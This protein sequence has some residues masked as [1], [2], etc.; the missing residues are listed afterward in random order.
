MAK[1]YGWCYDKQGNLKK[2]HA[3]VNAKG[4]E[5]KKHKKTVTGKIPDSVGFSGFRA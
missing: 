4:K 1:N 3:P 2:V 5:V